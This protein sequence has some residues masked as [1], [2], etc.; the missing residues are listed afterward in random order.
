MHNLGNENDLRVLNNQRSSYN[1]HKTKLAEFNARM[2]SS[3]PWDGDVN[4]VNWEGTLDKDVF[5]YYTTYNAG[6]EYNVFSMYEDM[7]RFM[8]IF[9]AQLRQAFPNYT[10]SVNRMNWDIKI[11]EHDV[12]LYQK[13][14][15]HEDTYNSNSNPILPHPSDIDS[16][17]YPNLND[18]NL[19]DALSS[20][21]PPVYEYDSGI[22]LQ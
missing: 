7:L 21:D 12:E 17:L 11:F 16:Y 1:K 14:L 6:I 3:E 18:M 19:D 20:I 15:E 2:A 9:D 5:D 13:L 8:L 22:P 10:F 4:K